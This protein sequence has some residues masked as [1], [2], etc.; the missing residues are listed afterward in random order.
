MKYEEEKRREDR[1]DNG[2]AS[3]SQGIILEINE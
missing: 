3:L 2:K 1:I